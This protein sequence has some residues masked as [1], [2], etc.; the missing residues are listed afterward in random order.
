LLIGH[1]N[2]LLS[3][4]HS[5][6]TICPEIRDDRL[7]LYYR[8]GAIASI[9]LKNRV[10]ELHFDNRHLNACT[11]DWAME[12]CETVRGATTN[13]QPAVLVDERATINSIRRVPAYKAC[14]DQY[15]RQEGGA[16]RELQ[17]QIVREN[18]RAGAVANSTD[19][20]VCDMETAEAVNITRFDLVG[21]H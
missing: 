13:G 15:F 19:Y 12:W 5:D 14:M 4:L 17:Q 3:F 21:V 7:T 9:R 18:N 16:E 1:L 10:Y 8:G 11:A 6:H 20:Y 2:P